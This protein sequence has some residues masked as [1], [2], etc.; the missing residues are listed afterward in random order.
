LTITTARLELVAATADLCEVEVAGPAAFGE[1]L[2][3]TVPADWPP[4][5]N[6][7]HSQRFFLQ[8]L[9]SS[10]ESVG[11]CVWYFIARDGT[12]TAV[13]NGGFKGPPCDGAVELGY[14]IVPA[15]QRRRYAS[16]A[17]DALVRWAFADPRVDR[18]IAETFP[19][20]AGSIGV[21]AASGFRRCDGASEPGA[22]RFE[23]LRTAA[24]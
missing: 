6:D 24:A 3:V 5:L 8:T 10:P 13:G 15:F 7:E 9:R 19:D 16:E 11:W 4:P 20:N 21:L 17:V 1:A 18:V 14:S 23:R 22:I 12:R 2:G